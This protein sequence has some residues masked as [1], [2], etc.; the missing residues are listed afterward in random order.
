MTSRSDQRWD[1][2]FQTIIRR[3]ESGKKITRRMITWY[4]RQKKAI[5]NGT[6][7]QYRRQQIESIE[8]STRPGH[9]KAWAEK[10]EQLKIYMEKH[11]KTPPHIRPARF[12]PEKYDIKNKKWIDKELGELHSLSVWVLTQ[13]QHKKLGNL[14][15]SREEKLNRI[16][17]YFDARN[18]NWERNYE[19]ILIEINELGQK[20]DLSDNSNA[21]IRH[22]IKKKKAGLLNQSEIKKINEAKQKYDEL[23]DRYGIKWEEQFIN[24]QNFYN[25]YGRIPKHDKR[26][27]NPP[28]EKERNL[29]VWY[30]VQVRNYQTGYLED[31]RYEKLNKIIPNFG[32]RKRQDKESWKHTYKKY[33]Q[34]ISENGR[35]PSQHTNSKEEARLGVWTSS[36]RQR[37]HRT[38]KNNSPLSKE[39]IALLEKINFNFNFRNPDEP[40]EEWVNK[41]DEYINYKNE[42]FL[43]TKNPRYTWRRKQ[44]KRFQKNT[45]SKNKIKL[46]IQNGMWLDVEEINKNWLDYYNAAKAMIE[47]KEKTIPKNVGEEINE[48]YKWL[49]YN[50]VCYELEKLPR[51]KEKLIE[52]INLNFFE[53]S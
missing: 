34:F 31:N 45:L 28:S 13:R 35:E 19:Q 40:L 47:L 27:H 2:R 43:D 39:Q 49:I 7:S 21:W 14:K 3:H 20:A 25:N 15:K 9:Q 29:G 8:I 4:A 44:R 36:N 30:K 26:V 24:F 42:G 50:L 1:S 41:L 38:A 23:P 53:I 16:G 22:Q 11:G 51:D 32:K 48:L 52:K 12:S 6:L 18:K 10:Y 5:E 46:L 17:F 37:Y 33:I